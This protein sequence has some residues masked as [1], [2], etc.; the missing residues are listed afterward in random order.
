MHLVGLQAENFRNFSAVQLDFSKHTNLIIGS[1]GSGKSNLLE[2]IYFSLFARSFKTSEDANLIKWKE[3]YFRTQME[4]Q[5]DGL[6]KTITVSF[7]SDRDKKVLLNHIPEKS[8]VL[9]RESAVIVFSPSTSQLVKGLPSVR[10]KWL[11]RILLRVDREFTS[12]MYSYQQTLRNRNALLKRKLIQKEDYDLYELLTTNLI[13]LTSL[14]RK[15]RIELIKSINSLI[16]PTV[17][18]MVLS[19]FSSVELKYYNARMPDDLSRLAK[20]EMKR[21]GTLIGAHLDQLEV[22]HGEASVRDFS[23]EGEQ[24]LISFCLK[25]CEFDLIQSKTKNSPVCLIDDLFSELDEER[26]RLL[27]D[28]VSSI[29]QTIFTDLTGNKLTADKIISLSREEDTICS[30]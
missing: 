2:L 17:S 1:N 9:Y 28:Y 12:I 5:K 30:R 21:G 15:G 29:S 16:P 20:E 10:R 27:F 18:S 11:D 3:S 22:F 23:S 14:I 26:A 25:L 24:K 19:M 4:F 6:Q 7:N 13:S 8:S